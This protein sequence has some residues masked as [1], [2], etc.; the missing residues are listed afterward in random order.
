MFPTYIMP[1]IM[2]TAFLGLL[3]L[4]FTAVLWIHAIIMLTF[5]M[6]GLRIRGIKKLAQ[7]YWVKESGQ[8]P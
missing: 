1:G 4:I 5:H 2:L 8:D 6:R 3:Y 7:S